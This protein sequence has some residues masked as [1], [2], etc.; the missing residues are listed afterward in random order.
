MRKRFTI[1]DV[2]RLAGVGKVTV[3]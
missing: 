3:S 1:E 2:A